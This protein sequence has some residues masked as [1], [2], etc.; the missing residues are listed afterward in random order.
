MLRL[1]LE[2]GRGSI[3]L[4]P[5]LTVVSGL[6]DEARDVVLTALRRLASG[7]PGAVSGLVED[8]GLLLE[9]TA[10]P[11]PLEDPETDPTLDFD[12][13]M[14]A[15]EV[16]AALQAALDQAH[17]RAQIDAVR[18]EEARNELRPGIAAALRQL[19]LELARSRS[20]DPASD[21]I[22]LEI[23]AALAELRSVPALL[24]TPDPD[25]E[26][27]RTS[28]RAFES[29]HREVA[30]H[31]VGLDRRQ[32]EADQELLDARA[33]LTRA[34]NDAAPLLLDPDDEARLEELANRPIASGRLNFRAKPPRTPE[35]EAEL[36]ELLAAVD[37]PTYSAYVMYRLRPTPR[38]DAAAM[39][40][41]ARA[42]V[43]MATESAA[44]VARTIASDPIRVEL[45]DLR[46]DLDASAR[47]V[48]GPV[49]PADL[50][51]A[52]D[53]LVITERNPDH[54]ARLA[55]VREALAANEVDVPDEI[56]ADLLAGWVES[57]CRQRRAELEGWT[58]DADELAALEAE[59][60]RTRT[61][62]DR[63]E[64][65]L[66]RI[67]RLED[68][69]TRSLTAFRRAE[70]EL[71][72]SER[73][74]VTGLADALVRLRAR[75]DESRGE[76]RPTPLVITSE[77]GELADVEIQDLLDVLVETATSRQVILV[78]DHPVARAWTADAG[79]SRAILSRVKV[80]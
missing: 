78:S 34:E 6:D 52:I 30:D 32:R 63:H 72:A 25:V 79:L 24:E 75:L 77:F 76:S 19:E 15:G 68:D 14:A 11:S 41:Q 59:V 36:A 66:L 48:M 31:L 43:M 2:H 56:G 55:D 46:R 18:V 71:D 12:R 10:E 17:R 7:R 57:W 1:D 62:L 69:A 37:Q 64:S 26:A 65:A 60:A 54:D 58:L 47:L 16:R 4:H 23:E 33:E 73:G 80:A 28:W 45:D 50:G 20:V 35:E 5:F 9:V 39:L 53:R 61:I 27:L 70:A 38:G 3:D 22:L 49:L 51:A 42:K 29:R 74:P 13:P 8:G 67:D 21:R 40:D 44:A